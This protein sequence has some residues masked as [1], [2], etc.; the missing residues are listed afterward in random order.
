MRLLMPTYGLATNHHTYFFLSPRTAYTIHTM[1]HT[2]AMI[3]MLAP[4]HMIFQPLS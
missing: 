1:R 2:V 3:I 4:N